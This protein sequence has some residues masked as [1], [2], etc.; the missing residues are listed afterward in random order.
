MSYVP[1]IESFGKALTVVLC[2]QNKKG[3]QWRVRGHHML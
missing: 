1:L 2:A 3:N